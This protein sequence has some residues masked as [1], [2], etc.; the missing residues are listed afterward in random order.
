MNYKILS[1]EEDDSGPVALPENAVLIPMSPLSKIC[2]DQRTQNQEQV[3][4]CVDK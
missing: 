3:D 1:W 4:I 2:F